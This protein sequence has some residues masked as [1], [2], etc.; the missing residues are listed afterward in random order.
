MSERFL[1]GTTKPSVASSTTPLSTF[2]MSSSSLSS[3]SGRLSAG[4]CW[5]QLHVMT[6]STLRQITS[7]NAAE[8]HFVL[9][10]YNLLPEDYIETIWQSCHMQYAAKLGWGWTWKHLQ[11][12]WK[13]LT[14]LTKVSCLST[15]CRCANSQTCWLLRPFSDWSSFKFCCAWC[16]QVHTDATNPGFKQPVAPCER[17]ALYL[18][19]PFFHCS[20]LCNW[21][22]GSFCKGWQ[23]PTVVLQQIHSLSFLFC[24][25]STSS[26]CLF[27]S[28]SFLFCSPSA[29]IAPL[30]FLLCSLSASSW[31]L[32]S[33][34]FLLSIPFSLHPFSLFSFCSF[35]SSSCCHFSPFCLLHNLCH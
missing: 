28:F 2:S 13:H 16:K 23:G 17:R 1:S 29:S 30:S 26:C 32:F 34:L 33:S 5:N 4:S 27:S 3:Q 12:L 10:W 19:G 9:S 15:W 11:G 21:M 31:C 18:F 25:F 6:I 14:S 20:P 7:V 22:A 24:S 35:P 8:L